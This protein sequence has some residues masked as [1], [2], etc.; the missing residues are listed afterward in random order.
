M[1]LRVGQPLRTMPNNFDMSGINSTRRFAILMMH[2]VALNLLSGV[3]TAGIDAGKVFNTWPTMNG[4]L[5]PSAYWKSELGYRN[6]FENLACVQFNHRVLAYSTFIAAYAAIKVTWAKVL[7]LN[8]RLALFVM[9]GLVNYQALLGIV[10]LMQQVP[11]K[12]GVQHQANGL[13][14][15]S[16]VVYL[17]AATRKRGFVFK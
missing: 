12:K 14:I 13:L 5:V 1:A 16:T 4:V 3:A 2:F 11:I 10:M 17:L 9:F 15:L 7:P 8:I 6:L